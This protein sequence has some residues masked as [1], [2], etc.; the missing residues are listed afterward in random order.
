MFFVYSKQHSA[1]RNTDIRECV[2]VKINGK[3]L[4]HR[5]AQKWSRSH[6]G[7]SNLKALTGKKMVFWIG[8]RFWQV[9]AYER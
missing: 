3:S 5:Q 6:T 4:I 1:H 8:G 7:G 2:K 9:V